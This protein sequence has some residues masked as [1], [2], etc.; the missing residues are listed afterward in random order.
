MIRRRSPCRRVTDW[1]L[2][3]GQFIVLVVHTFSFRFA[4]FWFVSFFG[5]ICRETGRCRD[6]IKSRYQS[7][8][9]TVSHTL[10]YSIRSRGY[11][12]RR[13][14]YC[15]PWTPPPCSSARSKR[16]ADEA[17]PELFERLPPCDRLSQALG[18]FA[19]RERGW[20]SARCQQA[21]SLTEL[22]EWVVHKPPFF[23]LR[24]ESAQGCC[25]RL[26]TIGCYPLQQEKW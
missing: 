2:A 23:H 20:L 11:I 24:A 19:P 8:S 21:A 3:L 6:P 22:I 7:C 26:F 15:L 14:A 18:E 5:E 13:S 4:W 9:R 10:R 25:S 17:D 16:Q 12:W 1:A